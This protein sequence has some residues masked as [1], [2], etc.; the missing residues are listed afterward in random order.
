[1]ASKKDR[2][3]KITTPDGEKM[4]KFVYGREAG[5]E[6]HFSFCQENCK[7]ANCC[8]NLP[9]PDL[10]TPGDNLM[11]FCIAQDNKNPS[12]TNSSMNAYY[13]VDI[14]RYIPGFMDR[15]LK[16]DPRFSLEEI[17]NTICREFCSYY[18]E[19]KITDECSEKN[20]MCILQALLI[21]NKTENN[22]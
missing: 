13:P 8:E 2:A 22:D 1:M 19:G 16:S 6:E 4:I 10:N 18:T 12:D 11:D 15:I 14:E 7:Y 21:R 3:V 5:D 9:N 17:H 20:P